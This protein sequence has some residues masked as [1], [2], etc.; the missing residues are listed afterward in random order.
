MAKPKVE[1]I[2]NQVLGSSVS[3]RL[4]DIF[5]SFTQPPS[6]KVKLR[7]GK[8]MR[9]GNGANGCVFRHAK[10]S[11]WRYTSILDAAMVSFS[12][13]SIA[14]SYQNTTVSKNGQRTNATRF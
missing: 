1:R 8:G 4:A 14:S 11:F 9:C 13:F 5:S 2:R 3:R 10:L 6:C 12:F 7:H